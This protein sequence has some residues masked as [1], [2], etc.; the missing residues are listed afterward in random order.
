MDGLAVFHGAAALAF[1]GV[2]A[3]AAVVA[4]LA[5]T[6]ALALILSFAGVVLGLFL[7]GEGVSHTSFGG[8]NAGLGARRLRGE[9][10]SDQTA[11]SGTSEEGL[12][13][14][15]RFHVVNDFWI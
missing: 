13:K 6:F 5:A 14:D 4:A 11:D 8:G 1:A 7:L 9:S 3:C 15:S 2:L 12:R 10:T